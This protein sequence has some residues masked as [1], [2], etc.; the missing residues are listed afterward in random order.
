LR[1]AAAVAV[2]AAGYYAFTALGK[3]LLLT[4]PAGAFWPSAGLGI[5]V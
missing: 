5:A 3:A 4:G 1:Y 2:I